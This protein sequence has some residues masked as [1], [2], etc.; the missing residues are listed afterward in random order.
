MYIQPLSF[1]I[2]EILENQTMESLF[3]IDES[4]PGLL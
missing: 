2:L 4:E 1:A 3:Q